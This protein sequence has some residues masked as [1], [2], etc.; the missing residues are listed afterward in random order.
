MP[1]TTGT[2]LGRYPEAYIFGTEQ[3]Y[4]Q[5]DFD[6]MWQA[7]FELAEV[8]YGRDLGVVWHQI[9]HEFCSRIGELTK[10]PKLAQELMRHKGLET[11]MLYMKSRETRKIQ[12][13]ARLARR[14]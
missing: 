5:L 1:L 3:R 4:R 6:R 10:D 14:A 11:T 2:R 7:L 8:P 13:L 9:R 12:A